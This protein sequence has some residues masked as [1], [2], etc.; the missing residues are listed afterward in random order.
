MR[1]KIEHGDG[2]A[3][4]PHRLAVHGAL[5]GQEVGVTAE[6]FEDKRRGHAERSEGKQR[7]RKRALQKASRSDELESERYKEPRSD[8]LGSERYKKHRTAMRERESGKQSRKA[9]VTK[10]PRTAVPFMELSVGKRW[11]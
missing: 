7:A 10:K 1:E 5:G 6:R 9:S 2:T 11:G 8:E 3:A 4:L